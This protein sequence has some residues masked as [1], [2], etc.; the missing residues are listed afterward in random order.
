MADRGPDG[1]FL[2][3]NLA[4][5]GKDAFW[6]L[7]RAD[8]KIIYGYIRKYGFMP[9]NELIKIPS[10]PNI[11]INAI[12]GMIIKNFAEGL[13]EGNLNF[14]KYI[15]NLFGI[16]E[17]KAMAIHEVDKLNQDPES[18]EIKE[19]NLTKEEKLLLVDKFKDLIEQEENE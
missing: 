3:G 9:I 13:K 15:L 1:R 7:R 6:R 8:R 10:D 17:V 4:S 16:V 5:E 14:L 12:E 11:E 19:L 18:A 2:P